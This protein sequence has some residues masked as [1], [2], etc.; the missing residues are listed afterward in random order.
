[1]EFPPRK[2]GFPDSAPLRFRQPA[3]RKNLADILGTKE[4]ASKLGIGNIC[5]YVP[6]Y[7]SRAAEGL[8]CC[9]G[10]FPSLQQ[11]LAKGS[12]V[13]PFN[14]WSRSLF[15]RLNGTH[16]FFFCRVEVA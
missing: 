9:C 1:M 2:S 13:S 16:Q 4:S 8:A 7:S 15:K 5:G 3:F 6:D 14:Q 12:V 10:T 11:H